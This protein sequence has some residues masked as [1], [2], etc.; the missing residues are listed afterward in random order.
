MDIPKWPGV[1]RHRANDLMRGTHDNSNTLANT[2]SKP[3][4]LSYSQPFLW[5][6]NTITIRSHTQPFLWSANTITIRSHTQAFL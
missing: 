6:A 5:S 3:D 2:N 1:V 4:S